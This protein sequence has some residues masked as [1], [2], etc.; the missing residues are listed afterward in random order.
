MKI[1]KLLPCLF[2]IQVFLTPAQ[3]FS[4]SFFKGLFTISEKRSAAEFNL[5]IETAQIVP[6]FSAGLSLRIN[7]HLRFEAVAGGFHENAPTAV[8]NY[9]ILPVGATVVW[10]V[11]KAFGSTK[12]LPSVYEGGRVNL[13]DNSEA[14]QSALA[15][16][17]VVFYPFPSLRFQPT[18]GIGGTGLSYKNIGTEKETREMIYPYGS[19]GV[20]FNVGFMKGGIGAARGVYKSK[21]TSPD[22]RM[23][24]TWGF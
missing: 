11:A 14:Y 23:F 5:G 18:L 19:I 12:S 1:S 16:T 22:Y 15:R 7:S 13:V 10:I 3:A 20:E 21:I 8:W 6:A 4:A 24:A 9:V 2:A 17:G